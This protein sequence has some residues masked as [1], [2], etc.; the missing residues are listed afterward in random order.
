MAVIEG[1]V[2]QKAQACTV[3][4]GAADF[5]FTDDERDGDESRHDVK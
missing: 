4:N 2:E 3:W 5:F 1:A